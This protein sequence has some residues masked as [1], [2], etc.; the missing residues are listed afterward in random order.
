MRGREASRNRL[1]LLWLVLALELFDLA[2]GGDVAVLLRLR[3]GKDVPA[4]SIG[5]EIE[6]FRRLGIEDSRDRILARIGD[7][8]RRESRNDIS[9]VRRRT[10]DFAL[11]DAAAQRIALRDAVD[12]GRVRL[13]PH[14]DPET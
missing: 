9:V 14:S 10:R 2:P 5:D 1:V 3:L 11:A 4:G 13:K 12:D 7:R 6:I 8:R